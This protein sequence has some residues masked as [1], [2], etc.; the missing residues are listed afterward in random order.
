MSGISWRIDV[1]DQ[2]DNW[3]GELGDANYPCV[4]AMQA[5]SIRTSPKGARLNLDVITERLDTFTWIKMRLRPVLTI[6]GVEYEMGTFL[7]WLPPWE[8]IPGGVRFKVSASDKSLLLSSQMTT[9]GRIS[10]VNGNMLPGGTSIVH[11]VE[12]LL[13][14]CGVAFADVFI[15]DPLRVLVADRAWDLGTSYQKA[16]D[17]LLASASYYPVRFDRQ[18]RAVSEAQVPLTSVEPTIRI[19]FDSEPGQKLSCTPR[20]DAI[21][22][23]CSVISEDDQRGAIGFRYTDDSPSSPTST[24]SIGFRRSAIVKD[25]TIE[26]EE[27]A[28]IRCRAEIERRAA[29]GLSGNYELPLGPTLDLYDVVEIAAEATGALRFLVEG[30]DYSF[31]STIMQVKLSTAIETSEATNQAVEYA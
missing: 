27:A 2:A 10:G 6:D 1:L 21:I 26:N 13:A 22:N 29:V 16:I 8:L 14:A 23:V 20:E 9:S 19:D 12:E 18:S 24:T 3:C 28:A 5:G 30:I 31:N 25:N 11:A 15:P 17:E 7:P 4:V